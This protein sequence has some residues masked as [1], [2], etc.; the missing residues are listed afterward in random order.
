MLNDDTKIKMC[1]L[2]LLLC[3]IFML[4]MSFIF[5]SNPTY[6]I[7]EAV[8]GILIIICDAGYTMVYIAQNRYSVT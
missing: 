4:A 7:I 1:I 8:A 5:D 3:G 2:I 6:K